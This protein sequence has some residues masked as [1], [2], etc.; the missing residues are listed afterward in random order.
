MKESTLKITTGAMYIAIFAVILL[1]NRQTGSFFEEMIFYILPIPMVAYSV[2]YGWKASLP[3]LF[4]MGLIAVLFGTVTTIFYAITEAFIGMVLGSCVRKRTDMTKVMF[5]VMFLSVIAIVFNVIILGALFGY[6]LSEQIPMMQKTILTLVD[7]AQQYGMI[8]QIVEEK[9]KQILTLD[10]LMRMA[11]ICVVALGAL[12][13][14]LI[15]QI[16]LLTLRR[17]KFPIQQPK[18]VFEYYPPRWLSYMAAV[19]FVLYY[20]GV[21]EESQIAAIV[22]TIGM[23]GYIYMVIFGFIGVVLYVKVIIKNSSFLASIIAL[24]CLFLLPMLELIVGIIYTCS[25]FH[26]V[27]MGTPGVKKQENR[28]KK[29]A[30]A[31]SK[32]KNIARL[33]HIDTIKV[34]DK[35]SD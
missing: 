22:Q 32:K 2:K 11:I 12:Q 3:V 4:A 1:L 33:A 10:Y 25:G 8:T 35:E 21:G 24:L 7:K 31:A 17:L 29:G 9:I 6:N 16:S 27:L 18:P 20:L 14:F 23:C 34:E 19:A 15:F 26:E 30:L 28:E 13:G 5:I